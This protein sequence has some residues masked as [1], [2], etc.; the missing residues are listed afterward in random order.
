MERQNRPDILELVSSETKE[1][2][3][4]QAAYIR[5]TIDEY[6]IK[7]FTVLANPEYRDARFFET[8]PTLALS[9][10]TD[11]PLITLL[12]SNSNRSEDSTDLPITML[13]APTPEGAGLLM[14]DVTGTV[15]T[16]SFWV[17]ENKR[18][19]RIIPSRPIQADG[20]S[21]MFD[22]SQLGE[23]PIQDSVEEKEIDQLSD[24]KFI[25]KEVLTEAG[26]PV[27]KG[28][29]ISLEED[30]WDKIQAFVDTNP[31]MDGYVLK[32]L[33]GAHG[34]NVIIFEKDQ[35]EDLMDW[36][37]TTMEIDKGS[38]IVEERL[39][40]PIS[41]ELEEIC[42][43]KPAYGGVDYNFRILVT[44]DR[45]NPQAFD[46]EIR[47]RR[48][49]RIPSGVNISNE[50]FPARAARL[51]ILQNPA[52]V[53]EINRLAEEATSAICKK[54]RESGKSIFGYMGVDIILDKNGT[55]H[56]IEVNGGG[57]V[58]GLSTL[59]KLDKKTPSSIK[60]KLIPFWTENLRKL[61]RQ[62]ID[63]PGQLRR[64]AYS[65]VDINGIFLSS[66]YAKDYVTAKKLIIE[67]G[68]QGKHQPLRVLDMLIYMGNQTSDLTEASM[69]LQEE[70]K[71]RGIWL[72]E[73]I[74]W[75]ERAKMI[76]KLSL[77]PKFS[78]QGIK[79]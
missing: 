23:L 12:G 47:F 51:D 33:H 62:R 29:L 52:L 32:G 49:D 40:P 16:D 71:R 53:E 10:L 63:T 57:P 18:L 39:V 50:D 42:S 66:F 31:E 56:V 7:G 69:Y 79:A 59:A 44:L 78:K 72:M 3:K 11:I 43:T 4:A 73:D 76:S 45:S 70:I 30:Y 64:L 1:L 6:K 65:F 61:M 74:S 17:C 55:P 20:V 36:A 15:W 54:A 24:D 25:T 34:E 28:I 19:K 60:E 35:V 26:V 21:W 22:S 38:A 46:G 67:L 41:P 68:R 5:S 75:Q 9:G 13:I 14:D 8:R 2:V 77:L 27:P 37:G 48:Q 58:G